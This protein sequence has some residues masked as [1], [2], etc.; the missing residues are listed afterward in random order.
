MSKKFNIEISGHYS[1][2]VSDIWP[3][4]DAPENPTPEDVAQAMDESGTLMGVIGEWNFDDSLSIDVYDEESVA[5]WDGIRIHV[6]EK[7]KAE[8]S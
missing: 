1:L 4:G 2:S 3:D 7:K 6:R 8:A 5:N